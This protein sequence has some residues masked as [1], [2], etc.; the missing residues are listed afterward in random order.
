[1]TSGELRSLIAAELPGLRAIRHDLHA[2]PELGYEERRT[3]AVIQAELARLGVEFRAGLAGGTGVV[4]HLP[5][6]GGA[7]GGAGDGRA[8]GVRADIDALPIVEQ[9]GLSYASRHHGRMH[10]CGHDGHT[11]MLLGLA[12][13]L[14][15]VPRPRPVTLVFQPAEE[16]GG[17]ADRLCREGLIEGGIIG[18]PIQRMYG[19][20]GWPDLPVGTVATRPGPLLA[21]TDEYHVRVRGTQSHAA[22]PHLGRDPIVCMAQCITALQTV[23]SRSLPP[24]DSAVVSVCTINGGTAINVIPEVAEFGGTLRTLRASTRAA[25]KKRI[26]D[27]VQGV[28]DAHDCVAEI[29]WREGYPV[30]H[31]DPEATE[32]FFAVARRTLGDDRVGVIEHPTMGGEDFSYYAQ[33]VPSV[34]FCLGLRRPGQERFATLHQPDFDFNDEAMPTGIEMF[35]RLATAD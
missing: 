8:I 16:G 24:Q 28:C 25:C 20:H 7:G 13:V 14:S 19:L 21:S 10:A 1:M 12:R 9:T 26:Y 33:R 11:A 15:K 4:A 32:G 2:H 5:A 23:V 35:A 27:L 31:N 30:T 34:F 22:Y 6:T 3:S 17:G 18:P 29:D